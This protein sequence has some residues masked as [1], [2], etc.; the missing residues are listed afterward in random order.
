MQGKGI[1]RKMMDHLID[2]ARDDRIFKIKLATEKRF[3]AYD[4]YHHLGFRDQ[5]EETVYLTR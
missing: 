1:G 4:V 2:L 5:D 3:K